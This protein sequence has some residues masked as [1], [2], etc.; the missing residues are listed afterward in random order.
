MNESFSGLTC[1]FAHRTLAL[2]TQP[3]M[4][5]N[6][7]F[8]NRGAYIFYAVFVLTSAVGTET[9]YGILDYAR[10]RPSIPLSGLSLL[11]SLSPLSSALAGCS[12]AKQPDF[13]NLFK[14]RQPFCSGVQPA[15][16]SRYLNP[17]WYITQRQ[18]LRDK[19]ALDIGFLPCPIV[20]RAKPVKPS[21]TG[22]CEDPSFAT[23]LS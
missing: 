15:S 23:G 16:S 18:L 7:P 21:K 6:R 5:S 11:L 14:L 22:L 10:H 3:A 9:H 4:A 20:R 12:F 8:Y 19:A 13:L 1:R 2:A 17:V